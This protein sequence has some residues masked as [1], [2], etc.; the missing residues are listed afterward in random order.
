MSQILVDEHLSRT[1]V[2]EPLLKWITAR[3][4]E[5]L[6][7]EETLKDDRILQILR[8]QNRPTFVTRDAG[9]YQ[10]RYRDRRYCLVYFSLPDLEQNRL[11]RLL[12]RLF[13]LVGFKTKASRMGKVVRVSDEKIDFWQFGNEKRHTV[14]WWLSRS[15]QPKGQEW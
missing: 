11:P 15:A 12:R 7:P 2:L 8:R 3:K 14:R 1:E 4:I 9:F 5:E 10:K 6:A 13:R